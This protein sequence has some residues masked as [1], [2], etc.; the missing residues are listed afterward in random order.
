MSEPTV[1]QSGNRYEDLTGASTK[2]PVI[3]GYSDKTEQFNIPLYLAAP[4]SYLAPYKNFQ[5]APDASGNVPSPTMTFENAPDYK[6][7]EEL[8]EEMRNRMAQQPEEYDALEE[9]LLD[10][11]FNSWE[12]FFDSASRQNQPWQDYLVFRAGLGEGRGR[13]GGGGG[14]T[15]S[16]TLT[17]EAVAGAQLDATFTQYLGR[18][19][20]DD[21][22]QTYQKLLNA[23]ERA[24]PVRR[25]NGANN[26]T[27]GGFDATRFAREYAQSQEGYAERFAAVNFM[28]ALD[29]ALANRGNALEE[30]A[31]GQQ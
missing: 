15:S 7:Q 29:N 9:L 1:E 13:G 24:N 8:L 28:S 4:S 3:T 2:L 10:T 27:S 6:T 19:A 30:F 20:S 26:V 18:T 23:Q 5:R 25:T 16:V 31:K 21:E 12:E 11:R 17:N 14:P 22:V